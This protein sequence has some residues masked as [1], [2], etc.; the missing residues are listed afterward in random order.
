MAANA[1]RRTG[2]DISVFSRREKGWEPEKKGT[3]GHGGRERNEWERE[4]LQ[5]QKAGEI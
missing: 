5:G 4:V 1:T 2:H 3:K